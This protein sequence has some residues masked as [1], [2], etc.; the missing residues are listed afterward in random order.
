MQFRNNR[1]G[2]VVS[3]D[4]SKLEIAQQFAETAGDNDWLWFWMVK[5]LNET[6]NAPLAKDMIAFLSDS[7]LLAL[8]MGLKRPMI[9]LHWKDRRYKIYLSQRGTLCFKTGRLVSGTHDPQGDEAYMGCLYSGRFL[10][11][12]DRNPLPVDQEVIDRLSADPAG[13]LAQASKDM[14]R[15]CYCGHG[16]DDPR[17]KQVGY[18]PDCAGRWGLP[19]GKAYDEKVPS[20]ADL[21]R[22]ASFTD[23]ASVRDICAAIRQAPR[24]ATLWA[25][26]GDALED[27]GYTKKP[28]MPEDN[29]VIPAAA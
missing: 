4:L 28:K 26:L 14:D 12:R 25:V 22:R 3:T 23:Q 27:V 24:D 7:F 10:K 29:V 18:G 16:L 1:S 19:W 13:F 17:S 8:G 2:E 5:H 21:W 11:N 6:R 20:F 15:C 9:R